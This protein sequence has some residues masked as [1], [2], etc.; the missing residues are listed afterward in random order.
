[1]TTLA[2][3]KIQQRMNELKG[4]SLEGDAI[5]K[6]VKF[7]SFREAIDYVNKIGE[8]AEQNN[9]H[10]DIL[11]TYDTVRLVLTT[12]HENGL[13]EKD[14]EVAKMIDALQ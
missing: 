13:T 10:P 12:H 14:F 11:I 9:H 4:W 3:I 6:E 7:N 2:L 5:S 8:I 1:M